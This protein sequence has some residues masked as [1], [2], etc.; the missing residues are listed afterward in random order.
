MLPVLG[1]WDRQG[2]L[3]FRKNLYHFHNNPVKY[4]FQLIILKMYE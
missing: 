3:G 2:T 4:K 1:S